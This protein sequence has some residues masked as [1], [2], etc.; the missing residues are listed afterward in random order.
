MNIYVLNGFQTV[1]V[2][3]TYISCIW[4]T[5]YFS[6]GDFELALTPTAEILKTVT[7]GCYLVREQDVSKETGQTTLKKV[8]IVQNIEIKTDAEN[9]NTLVLTGKSLSSIVGQ[10]I[11]ASQTSLRGQLKEAIYTLLVS[12]LMLPTDTDRQ[13]SNFR[14]DWATAPELLTTAVDTQVTGD[15]L[16]EWLAT[17]GEKYG[18]GWDV[19][20]S[21]GF[22]V[23]ELYVG[24][25][26]SYGQSVNPYVVF[27]PDFQNLLNTDYQYLTENYK[28]V[29]VVAGEGEGTA[30]TKTTVGTATGL[31]RF[32]QWVDARD[33][34]SNDGGITET[35][36]TALLTARGTD[37]LTEHINNELFDGDVDVSIQYLPNKDYY[38]GDI[39]QL[40]ND[41]GI[42]ART[43]ILELIESEDASGKRV[44]PTF[45][46]M[47][48]I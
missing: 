45:G 29:A 40:Q 26:R 8:V 23:F 47:E 4:T 39:V 2:I 37:A 6:D 28:N 5:R 9:G 19:Y 41:Y 1:G 18:F 13:I 20:L 34:S 42:S 22:Y 36:Y 16:G 32:E 31:D 43:R 27:S 7:I 48:V 21:G 3:D 10:R 30:R 46:S 17:V 12:N 35:D 25:D 11:V 38:L 15:N 14:Y 24:T 44:I 33:I